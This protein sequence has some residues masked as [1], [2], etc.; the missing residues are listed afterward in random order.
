MAARLPTIVASNYSCETALSKSSDSTAG[1]ANFPPT[2]DTSA[3]NSAPYIVN[4]GSN[5]LPVI[6][7]QVSLNALGVTQQLLGVVTV[8]PATPYSI[9]SLFPVNFNHNCLVTVVAA[10]GFTLSSVGY[11]NNIP[12]TDVVQGFNTTN[13]VAVAGQGTAVTGVVYVSLQVTGGSDLSIVYADPGGAPSR[14]F[15]VSVTRL[16]GSQ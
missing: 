1:F 11:L 14:N 5:A 3:L 6:A 12:A 7:G 10:G 13:I 4:G 2:A 8:A 15:T 16:A 9:K